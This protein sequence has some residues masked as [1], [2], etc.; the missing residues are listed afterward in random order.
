VRAL[1]L[2]LVASYI[3]DLIKGDLDS[4]EPSVR[5]WYEAKG[6]RV[7]QD[8]DQNSTDLMKCIDSVREMEV[9][10]DTQFGIIILG[11]LSGRLDQTVHTMSLLHKLRKSRQHT[12]VVTEHNVAWVLD[13]GEHHISLDLS[14]IGPTCG[15]LPVGVSST[16]LSTKGL[17]WD[18][19]DSVSSFD[20]LV[21]TS[22]AFQSEQVWIKTSQPIWWCMELRCH[23]LAD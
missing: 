19:E 8:E 2:N 23:K 13:A 6:V 12:Y 15:L 20:G 9:A 14:V 5:R 22:N 17:V 16:V 18:L 10:L 1:F 3:P 21:S 4:L 11:G 7:I